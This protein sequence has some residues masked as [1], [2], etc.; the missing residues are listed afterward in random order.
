MSR[1]IAI[2]QSHVEHRENFEAFVLGESEPWHRAHLTRLYERWHAWNDR[3][4]SGVLT[5]PHVLLSE[6]S[7]PTRLGD[8]APVSG[9]G[10][11]SQ[12]RIRPSL[13]TG[14]H[15]L[16]RS[17]EQ[18]AEGRARFVE[19]VLLH[20]VGHQHAQEVSGK[21]EHSYHGHGPVFAAICNRIGADLGLPPVRPSKARGTN[22]HLPSCA[23]W[24]HCVRPDSYYLGA[25]IAC[26]EGESADHEARERE[27]RIAAA[28]EELLDAGRIYGAGSRTDP[29]NGERLVQAAQAYAR[30]L[31]PDKTMPALTA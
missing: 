13:L 29:K 18:F 1:D 22:A 6:P 15:R 7:A 24:P 12:I 20:E 4:Y 10:S 16:V 8:C 23:Q 31:T 26:D 14:T 30:A 9:W 27:R 3:W 21:R 25:V 11:R 5:P 17:G 2:P 19:D 28:A